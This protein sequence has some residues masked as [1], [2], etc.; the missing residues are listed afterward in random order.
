MTRVK[1]L[2]KLFLRNFQETHIRTDVRVKEEIEKLVKKPYIFLKRFLNQPCFENSTNE[3][4]ISYLNINGFS[5]HKEDISTDINL[6]ES[7]VIVL[8]ET[9]SRSGCDSFKIPGFHC[10]SVLEAVNDQSGGMA[11]LCKEEKKHEIKL[12]EKKHIDF[13]SCYIEYIK[14]EFNK[15]IYSCLYLHPAVATKGQ[16]WLKEQMDIFEDSSGKML[17]ISLFFIYQPYIAAILGDFNLKSE[18]QGDLKKLENI[19]PNFNVFIRGPTFQR[20]NHF[21]S[22]DHIFVSKALSDPFNC[23]AFRNIYSDHSAISFR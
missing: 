18:D 15:Q 22:I 20:S 21:S 16:K 5:S 4:K 8:A 10:I 17:L 7:D 1:A 2:E 13:D 23:T 9:K 6:L 14:A 12:I 19:L 3:T 11:L